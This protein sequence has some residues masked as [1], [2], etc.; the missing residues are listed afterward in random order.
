MMIYNECDE[1]VWKS[2][3]TALIRVEGIGKVKNGR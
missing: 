1:K 3:T 2:N